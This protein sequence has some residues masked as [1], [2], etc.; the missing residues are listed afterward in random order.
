MKFIKCQ[1]CNKTLLKIG[2]FNQLSIKCTRCKTINYLSVENTPS[3]NHEFL[4]IGEKP[5]GRT[6]KETL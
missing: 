2:T 5:R 1:N 3:E 4:E 6:T